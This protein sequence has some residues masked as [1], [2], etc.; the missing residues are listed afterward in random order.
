MLNFPMSGPPRLVEQH[1]EESTAGVFALGSAGSMTLSSGTWPEANKAFFVPFHVL[2]RIR[3]RALGYA[4][5]S[6]VSGNV[7]GG[8]YT[9]DGVRICSSGS[10]SQTGFTTSNLNWLSTSLDNEL[11][12]GLFYLALVMDSTTATSIRWGP[13]NVGLPRAMGCAEM[14]SA[15]PL[16]ATAT[17]AALTFSC[18]P[19]IVIQN[20]LTE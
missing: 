9:A 20:L 17:L 2:S 16:P 18:A 8:I 11:G 3:V 14:A 7:D 13:S 12:P 5:G 6:V 15:F 19:L 4:A 10:V 1:F